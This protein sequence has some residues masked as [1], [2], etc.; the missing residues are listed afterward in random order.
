MRGS[1]WALPLV[2]GSL[3]RPESGGEALA[4]EGAADEPWVGGWHGDA[5]IVARGGVVG[6]V[7]LPSAVMRCSWPAGFP[8]SISRMAHSELV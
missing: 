2:R 5:V 3:H 7:G 1:A 8:V 6:R 4:S